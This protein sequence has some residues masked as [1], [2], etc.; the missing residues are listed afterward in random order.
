MN[1]YQKGFRAGVTAAAI[2]YAIATFL[3]L[4]V[5]VAIFLLRMT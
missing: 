5:G 4:A 3:L 2:G 1:E